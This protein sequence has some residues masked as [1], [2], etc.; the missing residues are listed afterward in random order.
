M[1]RPAGTGDRD[2]R[3]LLMRCHAPAPIRRPERCRSAP[4]RRAARGRV[5]QA[6]TGH[7]RIVVEIGES[8]VNHGAGGFGGKTL[9]PIGH[10]EPVAEFG[11]LPGSPRDPADAEEGAVARSDQER[12][13]TV[14]AV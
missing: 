6:R 7:E 10:A 13:L 3:R 2:W 4:P 14:A 12:R 9:V 1:A 5:A 11:R 8:M